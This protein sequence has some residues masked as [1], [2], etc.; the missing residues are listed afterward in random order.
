MLSDLG[1]RAGVAF[2]ERFRALDR[3][4]RACA[5]DLLV[6]GGLLADHDPARDG[7]GLG[8]A[9]TTGWLAGRHAAA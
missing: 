2:D 3:A 6:C 4:G 8:C 1:F 7:T 5:A 9:A